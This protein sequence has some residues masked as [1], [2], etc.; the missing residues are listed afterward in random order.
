MRRSSSRTSRFR[1]GLAGALSALAITG[2]VSTAAAH[3]YYPGWIQEHLS[4]GC[5]PQC[6]LCHT[7]P[8]GGQETVRQ[9]ATGDYVDGTNKSHRGYGLF[10]ENLRAAGTKWPTDQK[11]FN[12][13]LDALAKGPCQ[14]G[15]TS[16]G[17]A[18]DSDGD[19]D[20]DII[21]LKAGNDPDIVG[22]GPEC[23]KYGCGAS[24]GS[25][26]HDADKSGHAAATL[27][28]LGAMLVL[29]RRMRR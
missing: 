27:A 7:S 12:A 8:L 1:L 6:T 15:E 26:P 10:V 23:P 25:L 29:A 13:M 17:I 28:A 3:D 11:A 21:E 2:K 20:G 9:S 18:C 5:A 19:G 4:S 24:I 22:A 14:P 16:D